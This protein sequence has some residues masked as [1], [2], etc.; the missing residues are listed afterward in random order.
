MEE[1]KMGSND[2]DVIKQIIEERAKNLLDPVEKEDLDYVDL[3]YP[4]IE[5]LI[6]ADSCV[7]IIEGNSSLK[8]FIKSGLTATDYES[9][10]N[11]INEGLGYWQQDQTLETLRFINKQSEL[12]MIGYVEKVRNSKI[13]NGIPAEI[14]S[15]FDDKTREFFKTQD[16][17]F[18]PCSDYEIEMSKSSVK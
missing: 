18:A 6:G 13:R 3:F 7:K 14:I 2:V 12:L 9:L 8:E 16:A 4:K 5:L 1:D 10:T 17:I 15:T 11:L